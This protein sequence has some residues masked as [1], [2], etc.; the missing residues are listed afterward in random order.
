MFLRNFLIFA[1]ITDLS[2]KAADNNHLPLFIT[3]SVRNP[4]WETELFREK[5]RS[6]IYR[7]IITYHIGLIA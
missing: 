6:D 5:C 3:K 7:K 2:S 1:I 4:I